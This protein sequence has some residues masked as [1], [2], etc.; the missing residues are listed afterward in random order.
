MLPQRSKNQITSIICRLRKG[1]HIYLQ[2]N[3]KLA[4]VIAAHPVTHLKKWSDE[5]SAMIV[6]ATQ[7]PGWTNQDLHKLFPDRS[8]SAILGKLKQ[9]R[10]KTKSAEPGKNTHRRW[11]D[12]E[13]QK[14]ITGIKR[15]G[16]DFEKIAKHVGTRNASAVYTYAMRSDSFGRNSK[17][18]KQYVMPLLSR[19]KLPVWTE[20][21]KE[22]FWKIIEKHGTNKELLMKAFPTR[23]FREILGY[24][25]R[26][27]N[28][29]GRDPKHPKSKLLSKLSRS[30]WHNWS[31]EEY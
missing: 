19:K 23:T 7:K 31:Q 30:E 6:K 24:V 14:F 5:E 15:F 22:T 1:D 18:I 26:Q 11:T 9:L 12:E 28:D 10:G 13:T 4:E 27:R 8:K 16:N 29:I 3:K 2:W 21:E 20:S 17:L 25:Y